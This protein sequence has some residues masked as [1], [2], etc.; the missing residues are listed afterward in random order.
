M[1]F[2]SFFISERKLVKFLRRLRLL[3]KYKY[4]IVLHTLPPRAKAMSVFLC[5]TAI[6]LCFR[7]FQFF[8]LLSTE[9]FVLVFCGMFWSRLNVFCVTAIP[10]CSCSSSG[11]GHIRVHTMFTLYFHHFPLL[12]EFASVYCLPVAYIGIS[13]FKNRER[14]GAKRKSRKW[15]T[16]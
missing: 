16:E 2:L 11:S 12:R 6:V 13:K 14:H 9:S 7:F 8:I 3:F 4:A 5:E 15:K 1:F 10:S